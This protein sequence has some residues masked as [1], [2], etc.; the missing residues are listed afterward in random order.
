MEKAES[1]LKDMLGQCVQP[2]KAFYYSLIKA[3]RKVGRYDKQVKRWQ[4]EIKKI[5]NMSI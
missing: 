5:D 2:D 1:I 4:D 3:C